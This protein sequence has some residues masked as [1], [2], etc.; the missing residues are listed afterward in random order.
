M[1]N[2]RQFFGAIGKTV[3]AAGVY[4]ML[5]PSGLFSAVEAIAGHTGTPEETAGDESFWFEIQRAFTVDR[6]LIN[7]HITSGETQVRGRMA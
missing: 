2:R 6:S 7:F 5:N 4:S 1:Y 3:A